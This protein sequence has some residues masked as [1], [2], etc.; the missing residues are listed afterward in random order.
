MKINVD[1]YL[2]CDSYKDTYK[3]VED[4]EEY[5]KFHDLPDFFTSKT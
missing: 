2:F 5:K 1:V 3:D 4:P